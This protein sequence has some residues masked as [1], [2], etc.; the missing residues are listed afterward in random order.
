[1]NLLF[2]A[3]ISRPAFDGGTSISGMVIISCLI[4]PDT[5]MATVVVRAIE[6]T[7]AGATIGG[8]HSIQVGPFTG[9]TTLAGILAAVKTTVGT[10]LGVT[11]Q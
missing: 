5:L 8:S 7:A 3:P 1:M 6:D 2:T 9:A 11:F 4:N 10:T